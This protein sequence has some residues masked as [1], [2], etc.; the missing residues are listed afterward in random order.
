[1]KVTEYELAKAIE[2]LIEFIKTKGFES[3]LDDLSK[4]HPIIAEIDEF[5]AEGPCGIGLRK[6]GGHAV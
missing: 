5:S 4:V 6:F 1:M 2:A 3:E